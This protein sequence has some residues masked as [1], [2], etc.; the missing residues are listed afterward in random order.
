MVKN[1]ANWPAD[2][3]ACCNERDEE[4]ESFMYNGWEDTIWPVHGELT[5]Y[6][7]HGTIESRK[8]NEFYK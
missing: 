3:F 7:W 8:H 2:S 6:C 5:C 4:R 1:L